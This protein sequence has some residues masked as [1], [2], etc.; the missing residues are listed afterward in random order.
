MQR[1][2]SFYFTFDL[3]LLFFCFTFSLL[4]YF[5]EAGFRPVQAVTDFFVSLLLIGVNIKKVSAHA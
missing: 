3:L 5:R 1:R 2:L 4:Y